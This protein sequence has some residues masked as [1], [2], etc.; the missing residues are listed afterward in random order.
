MHCQ[1]CLCLLWIYL[2][3]TYLLVQSNEWSLCRSRKSGI[4]DR[5]SSILL[6]GSR[7]GPWTIFMPWMGVELPASRLTNDGIFFCFDYVFNCSVV[8][9]MASSR[10]RHV[11]A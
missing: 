8:W 9:E 3:D 2:I 4:Q 11:P 6:V 10:S 5:P 7:M 1:F